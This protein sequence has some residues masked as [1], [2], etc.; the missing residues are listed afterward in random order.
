[1]IEA[2]QRLGGRIHTHVVDGVSFELGAARIL[3][4]Q[5]RAMEFIERFSLELEEHVISDAS[6][7]WEGNWYDSVNVLLSTFHYPDPLNLFHEMLAEA[8]I[9]SLKEFELYAPKHWDTTLTK[10]WLASKGVPFEFAKLYFLGDIDVNLSRITLYESLFFYTANL[11]EP[12][13]K[14]Y[15]LKNGMEQLIASLASRIKAPLMSET[16]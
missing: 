10:D 4:S 1:M 8:G 12:D 2:S 3:S 9:A 7:F 6:I 15:R 14:I 13:E 16:V 11:K 5:T